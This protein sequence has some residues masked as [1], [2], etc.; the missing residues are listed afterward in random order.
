M[1][2]SL[3]VEACLTELL[4]QDLGRPGHAHLAVG[5]SGAADR[6]ALRLA[7]RLV[8]NPEHLAGLELLL[9][10]AG[11]R[12]SGHLTVAVA[13][14]VAPVS[15]DGRP[16]GRGAPLNLRPGARLDVGAITAGLHVVVA[17]RGG[18]DAVPVL[19]SRSRDTLAG[20]GPEPLGVGDRVPVGSAPAALP[21]VDVA[22]APPPPRE[23]VLRL[24]PG[25]RRDW[26]P[27]AS[28]AALMGVEWTVSPASSRVGVR[29]EGPPLARTPA[30]A[31]R[32][33]PSEGMV[34]GA[35]QV[36][37]AGRPVVLG[38]DHP[39]T[40]GYPVIGVVV[41]ADLD[42]LAQ[43]PPGTPVRFCSTG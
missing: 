35:L 32:E 15:V 13:G 26:F 23:A 4:V 9:G 43:C 29:L 20:L 34:R 19:G 27:D 21:R 40:G 2:R 33:L 24:R 25:P 31:G 16:A 17:V 3:H 37:P 14:A 42:G 41:D 30:A 38:P 12:A 11:F 8:G 5:R 36:P 22:P 39:T 6:G 1:S 28:W 18:V 10:L 7:N